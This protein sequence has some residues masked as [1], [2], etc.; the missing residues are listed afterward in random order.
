[1]PLTNLNLPKIC[2]ANSA[3]MRA[4][5]DLYTTR[6]TAGLCEAQQTVSYHQAASPPTSLSGPQTPAGQHKSS[7][8]FYCNKDYINQ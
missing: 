5:I 8:M 3:N 1:M 2:C 7:R 6:E 4:N